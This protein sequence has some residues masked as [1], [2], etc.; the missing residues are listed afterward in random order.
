MALRRLLASRRMFATI[1]ISC[2]Q[3]R[4][5][6]RRIACLPLV[7]YSTVMV[8][9]AVPLRLFLADLRW[10]VSA[11][12]QLLPA[13]VLG[14]ATTLVA[15]VAAWMAVP[16]SGAGVAAPESAAAAMSTSSAPTCAAES[17][18]TAGSAAWTIAAAQ[19][20]L[21]VSGAGN[22]EAVCDSSGA[23]GSAVTSMATAY[24]PVVIVYSPSVTFPA[25]TAQ[26]PS[27]S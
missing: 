20:A 21:Y 17:I 8:P 26:S 6:P 1:A 23:T 3:T 25:V 24:N 13:F 2:V 16:L 10:V 12:G 27:R 18:V 22:F 9:L 4:H 19:I 5:S 15:T 7:T 11:T 14:T